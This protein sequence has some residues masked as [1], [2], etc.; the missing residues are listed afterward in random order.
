MSSNLH[1]TM[2]AIVNSFVPPADRTKDEVLRAALERAA[3]ALHAS[4]CYAAEADARR[5]LAATSSN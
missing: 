4:W 1:P 5:A 2:Q 3:D